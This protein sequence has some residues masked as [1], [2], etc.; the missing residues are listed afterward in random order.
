MRHTRNRQM[1]KATKGRWGKTL[2]R[3][4]KNVPITSL[5]RW[6]IKLDKSFKWENGFE[7]ESVPNLGNYRQEKSFGLGRVKP[8]YIYT[9]AQ[10]SFERKGKSS[11]TRVYISHQ[12][13]GKVKIEEVITEGWWSHVQ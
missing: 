9:F 5:N 8:F 6:E 13:E 11:K 4:I 1:L 7:V 3:K 12:A 10:V 2:D